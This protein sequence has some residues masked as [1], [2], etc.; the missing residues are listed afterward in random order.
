[1]QRLPCGVKTRRLKGQKKSE[2]SANQSVL[3]WIGESQ[4]WG[5]SRTTLGG[6]WMVTS[7]I[8]LLFIMRVLNSTV[9]S[10]NPVIKVECDDGNIVQAGM[11]IATKLHLK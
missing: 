4:G 6:F 2:K 1:M 10:L 8:F 7:F 5:Q 9:L 11:L 3:I